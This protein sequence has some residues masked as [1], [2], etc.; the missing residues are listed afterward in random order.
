MK[1][2]K[3]LDIKEVDLVKSRIKYNQLLKHQADQAR[4]RFH[5]YKSHTNL[6]KYLEAKKQLRNTKHLDC[7]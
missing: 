6:Q 4:K 7:V 2:D 5:A 1:I 3:F